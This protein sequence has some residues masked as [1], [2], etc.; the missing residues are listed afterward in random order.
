MKEKFWM[1]V[2]IN[3][4][5][6]VDSDDNG[7]PILYNEKDAQS[8]AKELALTLGANHVCCV[9]E[10]M[11]GEAGKMITERIL[12]QRPTNVVKEDQENLQ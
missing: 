2:T 7:M 5:V 9:V 8:R 10:Y 4:E 11:Y 1:I 3:G 12:P 6:D